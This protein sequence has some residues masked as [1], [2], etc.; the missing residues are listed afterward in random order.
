[1]TIKPKSELMWFLK[2]KY[3]ERNSSKSHLKI[4]KKRGGTTLRKRGRN[5][6]LAIKAER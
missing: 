3:A 6:I 5:A 4:S 1:M 2:R